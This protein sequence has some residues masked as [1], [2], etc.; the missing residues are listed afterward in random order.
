VS[1]VSLLEVQTFLRS[2]ETYA[3]DLTTAGIYARWRAR[4]KRSGILLPDPDYWIAAQA[5]Q[6]SIPLASADTDFER[7]D[8]LRLFLLS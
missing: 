7:F 2:F 5:I 1:P 8:E 6:H 3:P 4:L